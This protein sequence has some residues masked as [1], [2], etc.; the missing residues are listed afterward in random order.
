MDVNLYVVVLYVVLQVYVLRLRIVFEIF[1][2]KLIIVIVIYVFDDG[3]IRIFNLKLLVYVIQMKYI[4][5]IINFLV[6]L[7]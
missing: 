1:L 3:F 4:C 6:Y 5:I 7:S 2:I